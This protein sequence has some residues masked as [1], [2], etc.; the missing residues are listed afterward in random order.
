MSISLLDFEAQQPFVTQFFEQALNTHHLVNAYVMRAKDLGLAYR[1]ILRLAQILNCQTP[2]TPSSAC[3]Q[4]QPCRWIAD[5]AHPG[6]VTVSNLTFQVD[7][8][9]DKGTVDAK[10]TKTHQAIRVGQLDALLKEL[11]LH[12]GGFRRIVILSGAQESAH[13]PEKQTPITPP[14]DF[15]GEGF[16]AFA[17]LDRK[18]FPER[19]ANKFLKTLEE[20][21]KDAIFFLLTDDE[22]KLLDTIVSRCQLVPFQTPKDFYKVTL[23]TESNAFF[24]HIIDTWTT[25]DYLGQVQLFHDFAT[26]HTLTWDEVL[27][28]FEVYLWDRVHQNLNDIGRFRKMK[29]AITLLDKAKRMLDDKAKE[30]AVL[31]DLFLSL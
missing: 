19:L 28:Q 7:F 27:S 16:L 21:P 5:N 29:R 22:D 25:Q 17:P 23:S 14:K 26:Q 9:P 10:P 24:S 13:A 20:P 3:G 4:C 15:E 1:V 12:S 18:I 6:V 30:E 2:A 8:D 31:E 11:S